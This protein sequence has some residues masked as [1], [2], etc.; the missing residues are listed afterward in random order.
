MK[1][2]AP[3]ENRFRTAGLEDR[4][5]TNHVTATAG[6]F[7]HKEYL[8]LLYTL[9]ETLFLSNEMRQIQFLLCMI[10]KALEKHSNAFT[11]LRVFKQ[12]WR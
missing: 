3:A 8:K 10:Q 11:V 9:F 2:F 1:N 12:T 7:S 4:D 5:S 6:S